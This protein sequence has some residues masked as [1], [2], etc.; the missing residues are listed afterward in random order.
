MTSFALQ[1]LFMHQSLSSQKRDIMLR[2]YQ[3][4]LFCLLQSAKHI[5]RFQRNLF[6]H[7]VVFKTKTT[8]KAIKIL[9]IIRVPQVFATQWGDQQKADFVFNRL[10]SLLSNA[11]PYISDLD[12]L[13]TGITFDKNTMKINVHKF[14][15][16][17]CGRLQQ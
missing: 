10:V 9:A 8:I 13:P 17:V 14:L 5:S 6:Q 12:Y 2:L 3:C 1:N 4:R 15:L 7:P 11:Q 16:F